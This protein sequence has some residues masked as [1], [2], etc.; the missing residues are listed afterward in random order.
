MCICILLRKK[1]FKL[2]KKSYVEF[3]DFIS[4]LKF[5]DIYYKGPKF[6]WNNGEGWYI[7]YQREI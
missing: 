4:D 2:S 1:G 5:I 3:E 7:Q 6:T